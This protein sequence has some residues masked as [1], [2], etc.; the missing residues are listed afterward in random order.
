MTL[1]FETHKHL[2]TI[3]LGV[4]PYCSSSLSYVEKI[5]KKTGSK[6]IE[7]CCLICEKTFMF[8]FSSPPMKIYFK[9]KN[10]KNL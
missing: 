3:Q 2:E 10:E 6:T 9:D 8:E 4:C 7:T 1:C 5:K